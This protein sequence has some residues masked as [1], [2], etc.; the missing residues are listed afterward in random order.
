MPARAMAVW[1]LFVTPVRPF[2]TSTACSQTFPEPSPSH[3]MLTFLADAVSYQHA[4]QIGS[5]GNRSEL[6]SGGIPAT[7]RLLWTASG[8]AGR[9]LKYGASVPSPFDLTRI[10]LLVWRKYISAAY[11]KRPTNHLNTIAEKPTSAT[12]WVRAAE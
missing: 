6:L 8:P 11:V 1:K 12:H 2:E 9:V 3:R 4:E 7:L 10:Y 5:R